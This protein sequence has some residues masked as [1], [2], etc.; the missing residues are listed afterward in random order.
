MKIRD[1]NSILLENYET[2]DEKYSH[3]IFLDIFAY[4]FL[5]NSNIKRKV[6]KYYA[7]KLHKFKRELTI[8]T[9]KSGRTFNKI[10]GKFIGINK[11]NTLLNKLL[12]KHKQT[13]LIG[14]GYDSTLDKFYQYNKFFPLAIIEFEGKKFLSPN[15]YDYYLTQTY[16]K[17]LKLPPVEL[18]KPTHIHTLKF[19]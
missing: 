7:K 16:G 10:I 13:S 6:T 15:D 1:K 2:G 3:G 12:I 8:E 14:Y 4:D 5:P 9:N 19:L 17:Y 18:Q 11:I